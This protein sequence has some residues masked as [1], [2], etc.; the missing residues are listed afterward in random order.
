VHGAKAL[1][2]ELVRVDSLASI[3]E[4]LQ[5]VIEQEETHV[6]NNSAYQYA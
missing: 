3:T 2:K 6:K 1:K 5:Q 4:L